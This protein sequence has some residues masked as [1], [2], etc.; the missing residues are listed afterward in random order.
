[1]KKIYVAD[2]PENTNVC[3]YI[4]RNTD[5]PKKM[6]QVKPRKEYPK[7]MCFDIEDFDSIQLTADIYEAMKI[8]GRHGW[9]TSEGPSK[10]YG[11]FSLVY[12]LSLIHI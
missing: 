2:V 10:R 6:K 11:G 1:M 5:W 8:Y 4:M 3:S 12:N 9:N 7:L